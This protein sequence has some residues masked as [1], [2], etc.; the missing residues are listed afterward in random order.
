MFTASDEK[1][2]LLIEIDEIERSLSHSEEHLTVE[3]DHQK[4]II[5]YLTEFGFCDLEK[6]KL[7]TFIPYTIVVRQY[8][9]FRVA[10]R[11]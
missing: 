6:D 11:M 9:H 1:E 5:E 8:I 4:P 3:T 10:L 2:K 7:V